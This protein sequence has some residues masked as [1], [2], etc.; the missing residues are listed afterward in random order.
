MRMT[1]SGTDLCISS[2]VCSE[3][4]FEQGIGLEFV[5]TQKGQRENRTVP[6]FFAERLVEKVG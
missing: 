5:M 6:A 4:S 1:T 2:T 3:A